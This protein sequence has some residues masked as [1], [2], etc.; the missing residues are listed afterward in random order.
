MF[1][2]PALSE[3]IKVRQREIFQYQELVE[4]VA[5]GEDMDDSD[6]SIIER[7]LA[8]CLEIDKRLDIT[9]KDRDMFQ[10]RAIKLTKASEN[11]SYHAGIL[12]DVMLEKS[13]SPQEIIAVVNNLLTAVAEMEEVK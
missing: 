13:F 4:K 10:D 2:R 8:E 5:S 12:A 7:G 9:R 1:E 6:F 11:C 3:Q